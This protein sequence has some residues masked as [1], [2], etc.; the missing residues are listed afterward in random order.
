MAQPVAPPAPATKKR[1]FGNLLVL[2]VVASVAVAGG[3]VVPKLIMGGSS[4]SADHEKARAS[5][6]SRPTLVV[7]GDAVVNLAE[8]RLNRYLRVKLILVVDESQEK[9][10]QA[11]LQKNKAF[12]KSWLLGHLADR[13]LEE[14]TGKAAQNRLRREIRD[15][16]NS[17]LFPDGQELIEDVLFEE[18]VV[19]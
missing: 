3:L 19:Q 12:L 11:V 8:A 2:A 16:F 4:H 14:V 6:E 7:F 10:V 15:E 18:F 5:K 9:Q 17:R 1:G 13:S